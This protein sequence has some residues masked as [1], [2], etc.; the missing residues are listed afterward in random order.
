MRVRASNCAYTAAYPLAVVGSGEG[1]GSASRLLQDESPHVD[2]PDACTKKIHRHAGV[3]HVPMETGLRGE[4][5]QADG[6]VA[7]RRFAA[8]LRLAKSNGMGVRIFPHQSS[9]RRKPGGWYRI[10]GWRRDR[11]NC[12]IACPR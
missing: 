9:S 8:N 7:A 6:K 2:A 5:A 3:T 1:F 12:E 4:Y 11:D 10:V